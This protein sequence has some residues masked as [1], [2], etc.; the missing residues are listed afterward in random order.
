MMARALAINGAKRVYIAGRRLDVL[1]KAASSHSDILIPVQCDVTSKD[2]L[3]ALA[4]KVKDEMGM[5]HLVICNS[6]I[7]GPGV[8]GLGDAMKASPKAFMDAVWEKWSMEDFTKTYEVNCTAVFFTAIAFLELLDIGN[9]AEN[10]VEGTQTQVIITG[11]IASYIKTVY[12]GF[13][14][15]SSKAGVLQMMKTLSNTL[16]PFGI[17]TNSISPGKWLFGRG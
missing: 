5:V 1:E 8:A 13:A 2:S 3:A 7:S 15:I 4:A 6:G 10:R 14:Y 11:S 16:A 12:S 9:K 17:R